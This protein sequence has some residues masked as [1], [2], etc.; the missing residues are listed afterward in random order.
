MITATTPKQECPAMQ[1]TR[2]ISDLAITEFFKN[3]TEEE[4]RVTMD[5]VATDAEIS[6]A[7]DYSLANDDPKDAMS[8]KEFLASIGRGN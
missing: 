2:E 1:V 6:A 3:A 8:A 7:I 4:L 5:D